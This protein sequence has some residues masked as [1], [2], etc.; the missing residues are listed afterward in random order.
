MSRLTF[1]MTAYALLMAAFAACSPV[2][3]A[4][5]QA[6]GK[7]DQA[8]LTQVA[9]PGAAPGTCWGKTVSPALFETVTEQVMVRPAEIAPDGTVI[10]SAVFETKTQQQM[11][12][13]RQETWFQTLCSADLTP[14]FIASVQRALA[15][16]NL[17]AGPVTGR[18]DSRTRAA[19]R[20]YQSAQ[21]LDSGILSLTSARALG[22]SPAV[23]ES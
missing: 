7:P 22:L 15:V 5:V 4:D 20:Q 16:R 2:P 8:F 6:L 23:L 21:G 14:E 9:P 3:T 11:L 19:V 12:R 10:A 13:E 1:Q 17:Y 18:M